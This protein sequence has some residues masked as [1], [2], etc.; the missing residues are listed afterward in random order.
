MSFLRNAASLIRDPRRNRIGPIGLH[1]AR[2]AVNLV[3]LELAHG[4]AAGIRAWAS[5]P[6]GGD[7]AELAA[8]PKRLGL[9]LRKALVSGDFSGRRAVSAMPSGMVKIHSVTYRPTRERSDAEEILQ[10]ISERLDSPLAEHVIDFL[11]VRD[12]AADGDRLALVTVSRRADVIA[13]LELLRQAGLDVA[14]L[15][16]G[17]AAIR[18]LVCAMSPSGAP[19]NV[20]VVNAGDRS[21]FM[22]MISGRR[23]LFDQEIDFGEQKLI[24]LI[25]SSLDMPARLVR[26]VI[27]SG[28]LEGTGGSTLTDV[29]ITGAIVQ[30]LRP[31]LKRLV[32]EIERAFLYAASETRGGG[33]RR[34][35]LV[36]SIARW[37]GADRHVSAIAGIPVTNVPD[38]LAALMRG[39]DKV[40]P[41]R[42]I[43]DIAVATGLALRDVDVSLAARWLP[44]V[45][46]A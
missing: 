33:V 27:T 13:Y 19:E 30:I 23:L 6:L 3:Q 2:E 36:G 10:Q 37:P 45:A 29:D 38:P 42:A 43:P 18:R 7:D 4:T 21:S 26:D 14:A 40:V 16:I 39:S 22:T 9:L 15:E 12:G 44:R 31:E 25:A 17:P 34:V 28:G 32:A 24:D 41:E 8:S 20:L 5:V 46:R 11:P 35:Y 1:M